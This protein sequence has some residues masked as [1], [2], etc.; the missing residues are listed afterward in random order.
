MLFYSTNRKS[1]LLTARD[2][3]LKGLAP[4]RGLYM[5]S[6]IPFFSKNEI[7]TFGKMSYADIAARILGCYLSEDIEAKLLGEFCHEAYNFDTPLEKIDGNRFLLRLDRGPTASFK[8]YAARIMA[9][10]MNYF[11]EKENRYTS[12]LTATSGDTGSA[13]ASAFYGMERIKVVILYPEHEVSELQRKQMTTLGGNI[14]VIA[15]RGKFDDCQFMVKQ[16]FSDPQLGSM[17]LSTANSINIGR[18]L[19][20]SVYYFYAFSR[21]IN[22]YSDVVFSIPSGNF[23]NMMGAMLAGRMGLP[24]KRIV[25]SVN[26]N[27]EFPRFLSEGKYQKVEPSVNCLSSAMNVGHPSNLARL[28]DLFGGEMDEQG[29]I[30]KMPDL[31][32]LREETAAFSINDSETLRVMAEFRKRYRA[33]IEPHG[34]VGWAGLERYISAEDP[35]G[36]TAYLVLET[37][38]PAKFPEIVHKATGILPEVP[39]S[40]SELKGRPESFTTIANNYAELR[41]FLKAGRNL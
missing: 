33:L 19:P 5:P 28:V 7:E 17:D 4:D 40:V 18:L 13:V 34:A 21:L 2:A 31:A 35:A 32:R 11:L 26:S 8:D 20:Q 24:V 25:I 30:R 10:L 29:E 27:D 9:R 16:A 14:S 15:V 3:I 1:P 6:E 36:D 37:A 39:V 38:H 22:E 23:G 41:L 12:I